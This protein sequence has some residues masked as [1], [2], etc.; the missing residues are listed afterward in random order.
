MAKCSRVKTMKEKN[1]TTKRKNPIEKETKTFGNYL[2]QTR[3]NQTY[4][5]RNSY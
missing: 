1:P 5:L 3:I 2:E 4:I